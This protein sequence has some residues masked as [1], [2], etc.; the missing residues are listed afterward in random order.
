MHAEIAGQLRGGPIT[1]RR[2][3]RHLGLERRPKRT[4][5]PAHR[6]PPDRPSRGWSL[7]LISAPSFWGPPHLAGSI[8]PHIGAAMDRIQPYPAEAHRLTWWL[9]SAAWTALVL[10]L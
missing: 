8:D 9:A 2:C 10:V 6:D 4:S 1:T 5:L 3:Q 7:H